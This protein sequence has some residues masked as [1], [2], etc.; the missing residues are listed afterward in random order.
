MAIID[1][2]T[3]K[4][5]M[6]YRRYMLVFF[7]VATYKAIDDVELLTVL[8]ISVYKR[9]GNARWIMGYGWVREDE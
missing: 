5:Y 1:N 4:V 8:G 2:L 7:P 3:V 6:E 9:A